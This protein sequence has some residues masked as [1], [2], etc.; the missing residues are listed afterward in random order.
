[1][2]LLIWKW[3]SLFC[4]WALMG[5]LI[6]HCL[7]TAWLLVS[8]QVWNVDQM[9]IQ[10]ET[11]SGRTHT[12]RNTKKVVRTVQRMNATTHSL[13][14]HITLCSSGELPEKLPVVLYEASGIPNNFET[15]AKKFTNLRIYWTKSGKMNSSIAMD[16]MKQACKIAGFKI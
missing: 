6:A 8:I 9:G 1:M 5:R 4:E 12:F 3:L 2:L 13:T 14:L 10:L 16:W 15:K 7:I 11:T